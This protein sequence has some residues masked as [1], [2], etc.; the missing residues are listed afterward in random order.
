MAT[1]QAVTGV[2]NALK[3][4]LDARI[5]ELAGDV[6]NPSVALLGSQQLRDDPTGNTLGIYLHRISVDPYGRNRY[7][8][9]QRPGH[10]ARPELPVNLHILLVGRSLSATAEIS[11]VAWA[12]QRIGAAMLLDAAHMAAID[13]NWSE[14]EQLQIIPEEMSTEDLMRVWDSLPGDYRLS[15]PYLVKTLRLEPADPITQG[16]PVTSIVLPMES[17]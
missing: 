1:Y 6:T 7:L 14:Q 15:S 11:L 5:A 4:A 12:M 16:P 3:D 13:P 17:L 10:A 2:L 9:P 8:P